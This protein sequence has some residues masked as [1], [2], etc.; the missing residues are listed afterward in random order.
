M[1][2]RDPSPPLAWP[3]SR[4]PR[5]GIQIP[6]QDTTWGEV[7][8]IVRE[9]EDLGYDT[10]WVF[11]H[12][13]PILSNPEGPCLEGWTLLSGLTT[14][15][16]RIRLGVLVTGN[17]YRHPSL[18]AQ[19]GATVD[20]M[21]G[22]RLEFG[23]GAGWFELEHRALG[24]PF[25]PRRE[26][27]ER[28]EEALRVIRLLWTE[29]RADFEGRYYSL[30]RAHCQPRP[31][32]K[33]YP[34]IMV[35]GGGERRTL[36]SVARHADL[37]NTFGS[38]ETFRHKISVLRE[39]CKAEGRNPDDI[40]KS[41]LIDAYLSKDRRAQEDVLRGMARRRGMT[42]EE[43]RRR[44]LIGDPEAVLEQ[45]GEFHKVGVTHIILCLL[46]PCDL[47]SFRR[48]AREV[49]PKFRGGKEGRP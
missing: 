15:T 6:P 5:F 19:M 11:D 46:P 40:E 29:D 49:M 48:F 41:V 21:S 1:N 8:A 37:W 36:R 14:L 34:P 33:P 12:F 20:I 30:R 28:L 2:V 23:L 47:P 17:T 18:L 31:L 44:M 7:S 27:L 43:V 42:E 32:Q 25:P 45:V 13:F 9:A 24:I 3:K 35:G 22:G 38:P 26:R 39:H 16:S 4:A 10:A